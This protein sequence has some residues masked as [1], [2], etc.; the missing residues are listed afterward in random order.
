M[1]YTVNFDIEFDGEEEVMSE[2]EIKSVLE[3]LLDTSAITIRDFKLL[4]VN[5]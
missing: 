1:T 2:K 3:E 4:D 5:D